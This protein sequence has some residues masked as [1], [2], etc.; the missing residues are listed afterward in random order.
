[1]T[2]RADL[3]AQQLVTGILNDRTFINNLYNSA[4]GN[5]RN[6]LMRFYN[7]ENNNG[8]MSINDLRRNVSSADYDTFRSVLSQFGKPLLDSDEG[9]L[10]LEKAKQIAGLNKQSLLNAITAI[11]IAS[12]SKDISDYL[13][14]S[15]VNEFQYAINFQEREAVNTNHSTNTNYTNAEVIKMAEELL[16]QKNYGLTVDQRVWIK[17]DKLTN[18]TND[19]VN[20]ALMVGITADY[21]NN[22]LFRDYT[23]STNSVTTIFNKTKNYY[24]GQ[25][26]NREK[27]RFGLAAA[28]D[29]FD[30]YNV[31][32]L[33]WNL[34]STHPRTDKC[35]E[36]AQGS[37]YSRADYPDEPHF[38]CIC[39]PSPAED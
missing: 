5:F 35:D 4:Q 7:T 15:L 8:T 31:K 2:A 24:K 27:D 1:M 3:R 6:Y 17:N 13:G 11:I 22:T 39:F 33:N 9:Q 20:K 21:M 37:P 16:A 28:N 26:I 14:N 12:S 30:R 19:A 34:A 36:L 18:Q 29:V 23:T 32:N 38:G 25:L 10:R